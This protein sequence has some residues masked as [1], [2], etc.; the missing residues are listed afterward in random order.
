[1][2]IYV[3]G[4]IDVSQYEWYVKTFNNDWLLITNTNT[5]IYEW[6]FNYWQG[7]S[8]LRNGINVTTDSNTVMQFRVRSKNTECGSPLYSSWYYFTPQRP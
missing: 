2:T 5:S 8:T 1:M 7:S 4:G 6:T 3:T